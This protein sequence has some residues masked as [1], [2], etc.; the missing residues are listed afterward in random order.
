LGGNKHFLTLKGIGRSMPDYESDHEDRKIL[1]FKVNFL[2]QKSSESFL[3]LLKNIKSGAKLILMTFFVYCHFLSTLLNK[4][5]PEFQTLIPNWT[6]IC[7]GPFLVGLAY[8]HSINPGFDAEHC[9]QNPG[10]VRS[11]VSCILLLSI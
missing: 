11:S 10:N 5:G 9:K 7:Q 2:R 6:L 4:I 8:F 1:T 3:F